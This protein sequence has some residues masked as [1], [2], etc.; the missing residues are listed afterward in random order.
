[1][2]FAQEPLRGVKGVT[3][4][5]SLPELTRLQHEALDMVEG[6]ATANQLVLSLQPGDLTFINNHAML[7]SR[8]AFL[9]DEVHRRHLVRLWLRN[10]HLA[11]T[12]PAELQHGNAR[13]YEPN[14]IDETWNIAPVPR[15][16]FLLSERLC[17]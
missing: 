4:A 8:E 13:I 5:A 2:N 17:S 15:P 11:W 14:E 16:S 3:R 10:E 1:M 9:D 6:C 12:L 7:H